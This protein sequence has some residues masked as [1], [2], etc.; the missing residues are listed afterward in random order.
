MQRSL[1]IDDKVWESM[2]LVATGEGRSMSN[3]IRWIHST[4]IEHHM[5]ENTG[6]T[7]PSDL[8][9]S[10]DVKADGLEEND[11]N[12]GGA[13]STSIAMV[14]GLSPEIKEEILGP[15]P[16]DATEAQLDKLAEDELAESGAP[17]VAKVVEKMERTA[18]EKVVEKLRKGIE[19]MVSGGVRSYSKTDQLKGKGKGAKKAAKGKTWRK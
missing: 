3:Y 12:V 8:A 15:M 4:Y 9:G 18:K 2:R 5:L 16:V 19:G 7:L 1:W 14:E 13:L 11:V 10:D 6:E 17:E